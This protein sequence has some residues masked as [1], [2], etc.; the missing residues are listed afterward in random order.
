MNSQNSFTL[1]CDEDSRKIVSG[2][3]QR[4]SAG[5][6]PP[7]RQKRTWI[8]VAARGEL[9]SA[10][11]HPWRLEV[12]RVVY[13]PCTR[14]P[15]TTFRPSNPLFNPARQQ[16]SETHFPIVRPPASCLCQRAWWHSET[17][18]ALR[19]SRP[20]TLHTP[21]ACHV[22]PTH[23]TGSSVYRPSLYVTPTAWVNAVPHYGKHALRFHTQTVAP[24]RSTHICSPCG[25]RG[26]YFLEVTV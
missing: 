20:I 10:K 8:S 16:T 24:E 17:M 22:T 1:L 13:C 15:D 21:T 6:A 23:I 4:R 2:F 14:R 12:E 9:E 11:S 7:P 19:M 3:A 25:K 26:C 18:L 5:P